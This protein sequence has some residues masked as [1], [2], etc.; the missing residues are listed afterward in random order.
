M[1]K[2]TTLL[3]ALMLL[4]PGP[5]ARAA[6]PPNSKPLSEIIRMLENKGDVA[7]FEEIEWDDDGYWEI[8]YVRPDGSKVEIEIDPAS[9]QPRG[10]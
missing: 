6:P 10:R 1:S 9:G 7:H 8:E 2:L 3:I 4:Q 5:A